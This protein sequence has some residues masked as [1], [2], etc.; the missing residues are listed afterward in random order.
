[1]VRVITPTSPC[2]IQPKD[3]DTSRHFWEAF[4]NNE[5]DISAGWL[6]RFAQHRNDGWKPFTL[7]DIEAFYQPHG[8]RGFTFNRLVCPHGDT[9]IVCA[10]DGYHFT[11]G[12]VARCF[13]A[14]P[15]TE[16]SVVAEVA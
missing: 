9:W 5:T 8:H 1:M 16:Q 3:I 7:A 4:S 15:V 11:Y 6:V 2:P 13:G 14:S 12:F 10:T